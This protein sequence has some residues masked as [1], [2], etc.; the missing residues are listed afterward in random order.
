MK[1]WYKRA[2]KDGTIFWITL[3]EDNLILA[4][5]I[6]DSFTGVWGVAIWLG[7]IKKTKYPRD[8]IRKEFAT[9]EQ[10]KKWVDRALGV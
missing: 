5:I 10:A 7:Y 9:M 1:Q 4:D 8:V 2:H 6:Q 3:K